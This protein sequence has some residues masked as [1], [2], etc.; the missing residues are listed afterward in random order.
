[1]TTE[2]TPNNKH[3]FQ[4]AICREIPSPQNPF[5]A[6]RRLIAG[7]DTQDL[8]NRC[9]LSQLI[10]LLLTGERVSA[11][12]QRALQ[13]LL[14]GLATC[15]PRDVANRSAML[16]GGTKTRPE[17]L[18]P[19]GLLAAEGDRNG[20]NTVEQAHRFLRR[21]R[22]KDPS[23]L[24]R[25]LVASRENTED[26]VA[27]GFGSVYGSVDPI[28]GRLAQDILS[29]LAPE[30]PTLQWA[31]QFASALAGNEQGWL[32]CGVTAAVCVEVGIG[33]RESIGLFQLGKAPGVLALGMEQTRQQISD[34]QILSD[35]CYER[36]D[37]V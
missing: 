11:A 8:W 33:A 9:D 30:A 10:L 7:Y 2:N 14:V 19:I 13:M 18:L 37:P 24:A 12:R 27:P 15:G 23:A 32:I 31:D 1:M 3:E 22:R 4:T 17:H 21:N 25:S 6:E 34:R 26:S 35:E 28:A 36:I 20:A 16:A 29:V 5:V